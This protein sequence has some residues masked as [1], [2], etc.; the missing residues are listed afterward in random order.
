MMMLNINCATLT[1]KHELARVKLAT[2]GQKNS[3]ETSV[4][5]PSGLLAVNFFSTDLK[6][7]PNNARKR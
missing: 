5:K 1:S 2:F 3:F 7:N 6:G 4:K